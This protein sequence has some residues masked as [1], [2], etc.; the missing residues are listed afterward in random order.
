MMP[1]FRRNFG[2]EDLRSGAAEKMQNGKGYPGRPYV[3]ERETGN[4]NAYDCMQQK[5]ILPHA[6]FKEQMGE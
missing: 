4:E 6:G 5:C 3:K 1:H 2:R